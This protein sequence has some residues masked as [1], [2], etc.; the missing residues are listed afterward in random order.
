MK[1]QGWQRYMH[2]S[3]GNPSKRVGTTH[4]TSPSDIASTMLL[5]RRYFSG[6]KS[7]T[8]FFVVFNLPDSG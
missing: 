8:D 2:L 7:S 4:P 1:M 6:S 3:T 5:L